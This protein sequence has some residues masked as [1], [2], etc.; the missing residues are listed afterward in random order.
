MRKYCSLYIA[1]FTTLLVF[2]ITL[3][4]CK[5]EISADSDIRDSA[6]L[7]IDFKGMVDTDALI[8]GKTYKN[9]FGEEYSVKTCKFYIH[10]IELSNSLTNYAARVDQHNHYLINVIDSSASYITVAVPALAYDGISF[11]I[12]VDS[13]RNVSGAQTGDLDP[14]QGMF[15]T[16]STGYIMAKLEGTSPA[17]STPNHV[18]EYHIGGFKTTESVIRKVKLIFL[19]SKQVDLKQGS[20]STVTISANINRWFNHTTA[21]RISEK[22]VSMNPGLLATQIADNYA[23]MF[24]VV[25]IVNE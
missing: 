2:Y 24:S 9:A 15:W 16:W 21:I 19:P 10:G 13:I 7:K 12:G 17:A 4:S 5:K 20:Q 8:P 14:A 11:F 22:P 25:E 3:L 18:I 1:P 6:T 23:T